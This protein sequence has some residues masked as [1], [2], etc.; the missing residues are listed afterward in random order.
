MRQ[1]RA[2]STSHMSTG[3]MQRASGSM[4]VDDEADVDT[5]V[6]GD[7]GRKLFLKTERYAVSL[8]DRMPDEIRD[9]CKR[10]GNAAACWPTGALGLF[11]AGG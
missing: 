4:H 9:L 6:A 10:L 5:K 7:D 8:V 2:G 3:G 1:S 11:S